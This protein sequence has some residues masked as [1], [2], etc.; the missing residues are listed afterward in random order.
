M[1][2]LQY[3]CLMTSARPSRLC[4]HSSTVKDRLQE[5]PK[6]DNCPR[7]L[8]FPG[9]LRDISTLRQYKKRAIKTRF[10]NWP[11]G[12]PVSGFYC[13]PPCSP[14]LPFSTNKI[15]PTSAAGVCLCFQSQSRSKNPEHLKILAYLLYINRSQQCFRF[16]CSIILGLEII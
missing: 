11:M 9:D 1:H 14:P 10:P 7:R 3:E 12:P 2:P 8:F 13:M 5:V 16:S 15:F 4:G 6:G